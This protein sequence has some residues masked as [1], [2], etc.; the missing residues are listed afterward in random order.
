MIFTGHPT[1]V[2]DQAQAW[3]EREHFSWT[4]EPFGGRVFEAAFVDAEAGEDQ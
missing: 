4:R 1:S 2:T 3:A